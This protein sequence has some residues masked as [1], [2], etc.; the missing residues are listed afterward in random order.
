MYNTQCIECVLLSSFIMREFV[1]VYN[2][3]THVTFN[4]L[5]GLKSL[6]TRAAQYVQE[7]AYCKGQILQQ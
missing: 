1:W 4:G 7:K 2:Y 5:N 6:Q 3:T